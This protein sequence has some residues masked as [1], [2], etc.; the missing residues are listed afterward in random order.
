MAGKRVLQNWDAET[1]EAILVALLDHVKPSANDWKEIIG[2]LHAKG[3]TFS[4]G[5][6][7]YVCDGR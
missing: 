2:K 6:L 1:H 7:V 3:Y 5:A 4:E